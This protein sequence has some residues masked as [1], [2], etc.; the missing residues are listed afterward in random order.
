MSL[1]LAAQ[2]SQIHGLGD[3][4]ALVRSR[5]AS[6]APLL[7][8]IS[9]YLLALGGKRIRPMLALISAKA[10]G[11]SAPSQEL[12]QV[13]AGIEL[14]HMATLL[15]DDIIDRSPIRR[16][17]ESAFIRYGTD[18]TLLTGDFLLVRAFA[19]CAHLDRVIIDA[20]ERACV[21][22]VEGEILEV[23]LHLQLHCVDSS[24]TVA[25][26]KTAALFRLAAFCGAHLTAKGPQCSEAMGRFGENLGVAFQIVDDILDVTSSE[27]IL[28]KKTGLDII[29]RKPS[30]VNVLWL[31]S[32]S[33]LALRLREKP[34]DAADEEQF[35]VKALSELNQ[36]RVIEEAKALARSYTQE[37]S[38]ALDQAIS[39]ASSH[40]P[41]A[42]EL[43]KALVN[44]AIERVA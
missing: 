39:C 33:S 41:R 30:L 11:L 18:S 32:G 8:Q 2:L 36:S 6:D 26:K 38:L 3:V 25:R 10:L 7:T 31:N 19:L 5:L 21:E 1:K 9:D 17:K 37:A 27:D 24:I 12:L 28:G 42:Y 44:Y 22:L 4:E 35:R 16:H 40:D 34:A 13:A 15:H 14:I 43:L 20:T 23:P 29:E